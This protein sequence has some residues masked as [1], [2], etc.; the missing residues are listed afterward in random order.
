MLPLDSTSHVL[1]NI[2][3]FA[4]RTEQAKKQQQKKKQKK[5]RKKKQKD[6]CALVKGK[7]LLFLVCEGVKD[8]YL[9]RK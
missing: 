1:P 5:K 4:K 9:G 7:A 3:T 2:A 8:Y 6:R